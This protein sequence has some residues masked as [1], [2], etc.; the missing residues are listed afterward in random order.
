MLYDIL[1]FTRIE[2]TLS[3]GENDSPGRK[4]NLVKIDT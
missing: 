2:A 4:R 1:V 3:Q